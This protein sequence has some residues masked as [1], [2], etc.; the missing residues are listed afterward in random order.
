[1]LTGCSLGARWVLAG[2]YLLYPPT[3]SQPCPYATKPFRLASPRRS[4]PSWAR[5]LD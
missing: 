1:M 2:N 4:F 5:R 3:L